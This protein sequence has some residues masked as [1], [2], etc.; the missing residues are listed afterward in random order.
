MRH[1]LLTV[2]LVPL[3]VFSNENEKDFMANIHPYQIPFNSEKFD[4]SYKTVIENSEAKTVNEKKSVMLAAVLSAVIPGTGEIYSK[5][6]WRGALF[7]GIEIGLW[8]S[9]FIYEQK[10]DDM[11][12]VMRSFGDTHWWERKYWG[13]VYTDANNQGLWQEDPL[14]LDAEGQISEADYNKHIDYF[15]ELQHDPDLG[16]THQLPSTKTQQYYEMIYKY[17]HQFGIGWDDFISTEKLSPNTITYRDMR[18]NSNDYYQTATTMVNL[19][20]LNHL[21]SSIDAAFSAKKYNSKVK[22]SLRAYP[23]YVGRELISIYGLTIAW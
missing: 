1:L 23:R 2:F 6:Y 13:K 21:L 12:V 16:Y 4:L 5:S 10:G 22:L 18:N 17:Q 14:I 15:Q 11:D 7:A 19:V 20:L 8:S 9:Y 3:I